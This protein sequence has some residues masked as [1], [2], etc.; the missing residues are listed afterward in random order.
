MMFV[1]QFSPSGEWREQAVAAASGIGKRVASG[2]W[3]KREVMTSDC[4]LQVQELF[5][6]TNRI[7][8]P[9][10]RSPR[11]ILYPNYSPLNYKQ[12]KFT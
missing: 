7:S 4:D 5:R 6:N 8:E 12:A 1:S 9:S 10:N 3:R 11:I 2:K